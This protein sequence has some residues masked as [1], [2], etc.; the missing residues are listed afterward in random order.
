VHNSHPDLH[1]F[2]RARYCFDCENTFATAELDEDVFNE[3]VELRD[4]LVRLKCSARD[5]FEDKDFVSEHLTNLQ[6]LVKEVQNLPTPW[7]E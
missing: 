4:I 1:Y 7:A 6:K 2:L 5:F 3:L